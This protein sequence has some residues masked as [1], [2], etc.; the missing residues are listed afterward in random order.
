MGTQQKLV[1]AGALLTSLMAATVGINP[2][3]AALNATQGVTPTTIRV[4]VPYIDVGAAALRASGVDVNFGNEPDAFNAVIKNIN[5]HGGINGRKIVPYIVAVNPVGTAPAATAC[6]QLTED[7]SVFVVIGPLQATCYLEHN[8][9]VVESIDPPSTS[10]TVAQDFSATPP[11][12][13]LDPLELSAFAKQ[14][15]FRHKKVALIGGNT[16][17]RSEVATV[18]SDLAKLHVPVV[19]TAV[20]SAPQGDDAAINTQIGPIAQRFQAYGANE[21]VA[22]GTAASVWPIALTAIQSTYNPP[23]VAT[24]ESDLT[25]ASGDGEAYLTNMVTAS[26]Q[27]NPA[28]IWNNTGMQR[29]AHIIKKTYPSDQ[30]RA[31]NATLPQSEATWSAVE[32]ACTFMALFDDIATAAGRNLTVSTFVHAGYGLKRVVLPGSNASLSFGPNRPYA[33]GPLYLVHY[34]PS[35]KVLVYANTP[36]TG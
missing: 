1:V 21:V 20:I 33:H 2:A 4:G 12:V 35:T 13:A 36:V 5:Q 24:T 27:G 19:T 6:T 15:I 11:A 9:P 14:G 23:W 10:Q 22:V 32:E 3:S 16:E 18:Q 29:C 30:I 8:V 28:A 25:V 31:Y 34:D 17:D 26:P 7:D